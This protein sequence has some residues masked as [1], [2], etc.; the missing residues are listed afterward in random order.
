[1]PSFAETRG[2]RVIALGRELRDVRRGD[3]LDLSLVEH[4][5]YDVEPR[6]IDLMHD[7][8]AGCLKVSA[9][10]VDV[11]RSMLPYDLSPN[12]EIALADHIQFA[13]KRLKEHIY[14]SAPLT[15][16][17]Q[18]NYP[19][20]YKI[21][22]YALKLI[23]RD[24]GDTLSPSEASGI[25]MCIISNA[26]GAASG[27][28]SAGEGEV[29]EYLLEEVAVAIEDMMGVKFDREGFAFARFAT[30]VQYLMR[31]VA[32]GESIESENSD[33]YAVVA[34]GNDQAAACAKVISS[35]FDRMY[36]RGLTQEEQLYL[37][38]H[39]NRI[40]ARSACADGSSKDV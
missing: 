7:L 15:F 11:A 10:I 22:Q 23:E 27:A 2:N 29:S 20:E 26:Y 17:L 30:H 1:M 14:L 39:I 31:R 28:S 35:L 16:D 25:A 3:E 8:S 12:I 6:Y 5:F 21:A 38:L 40:C 9:Q 4:T 19:L 24:L 33:V 34:Q 37:I 13:I 36:G 18:Q 32:A